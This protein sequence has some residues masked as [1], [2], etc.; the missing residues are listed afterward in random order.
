MMIH[1]I[2][3]ILR[4][5][6]E[7]KSSNSTP[8]FTLL[9]ADISK[10]DEIKKKVTLQFERKSWNVFSNFVKLFFH[11]FYHSSDNFHAT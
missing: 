3:L 8:K 5:I 6:F 11:I 4:L 2:L 7:V 1:L 10:I 9:E